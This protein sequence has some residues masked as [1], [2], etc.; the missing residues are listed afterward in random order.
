MQ[1]NQRQTHWAYIAGIMDADG[2]FMLTKHFRK[3]PEIRRW[4]TLEKRSCT[5]LPSVKISMIEPEAVFFVKDEMGFGE[6]R[7]SG[8]RP[9]RPNSKPIYQWCMRNKKNI[10][11]FIEGVMPFLRVKKNRAVF[12]LNY[13]KTVKDCASPYH[14]LSSEQLNFRE[15]S[16]WKMR[17]L[18]GSKVAATTK[19]RG[20]ESI[21]DSLIS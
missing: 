20:C 5:Y 13:C 8:A 7:L 9:S 10:I 16:Y 3:T 18:N 21:S 15:Q 1:D 12:L 4:N 6:I 2:C 17:E 19:S 11:P 14:G